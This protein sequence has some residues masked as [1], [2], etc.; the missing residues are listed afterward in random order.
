MTTT[1]VMYVVYKTVLSLKLATFVDH[2]RNYRRH[3]NTRARSRQQGNRK[4]PRANRLP[5]VVRVVILAEL[6][7]ANCVFQCQMTAPPVVVYLYSFIFTRS[8]SALSN[9]SSCHHRRAL[10]SLFRISFEFFSI[11]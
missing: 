6:F 9:Q 4:P 11:F 2:F 3:R 8:A 7:K 10:C 1:T 5:V